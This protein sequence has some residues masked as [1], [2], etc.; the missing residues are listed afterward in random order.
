M[1]HGDCFFDSWAETNE[2][3]KM[4]NEGELTT[5]PSI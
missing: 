5:D 4:N 2:G 3:E 1:L